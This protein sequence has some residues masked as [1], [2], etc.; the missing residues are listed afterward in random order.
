M[1]EKAE[2]PI[3]HV[4]QDAGGDWHE[5]PLSEHLLGVAKMAGEFAAVFGAER[6]AY[7][8][9]LWHDLGKYRPAFQD[10]IRNRSGF[11]RTSA[12]LEQAGSQRVD[13]STAGAIWAAEKLGP[14]GKL[15]A[16][17][18]AG[19]HAGLPDFSGGES[20]LSH[21]LG[22][23]NLLTETLGADVPAGIRDP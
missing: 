18:I 10:Y 7:L 2:R 17:L 5:H 6:W 12:H 16:Y 23:Q 9:G 8:A 15:L 11:E 3:A 20:C 22:K 21:R 1:T 4:R 13:H 19:H 14:Q